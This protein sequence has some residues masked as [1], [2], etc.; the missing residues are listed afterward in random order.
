MK[1]VLLFISLII[2]SL[3][4]AVFAEEINVQ[5]EKCVDG[6]TAKFKTEDG[7]VTTY[8]FLAIDTPETVHP[9][10]GEE[11]WGKEASEYTCNALTK[12]TTIKLEIDDEA[13]EPDRYNRGLAWVF[14][15]DVL[16]QQQLI[17][18]GY[19][20][21]AYLYGNYKYTEIL[22]EQE[23]IAQEN[24][25]GIWSGEAIVEPTTVQEE[26]AKEE[27]KKKSGNFFENLLDSILETITASI[28]QIIDSVL[29]KLEDMI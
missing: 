10:K 4:T 20:K 5:L 12:A 15:D 28:N 23:K 24:K 22:Q 2:V 11:P 3:P 21:V 16:L 6:D 17:S 27:T 26:P 8:R 13:K 7:T 18:N 9:T 19:A 1:K 14:V 25:L 29:Q